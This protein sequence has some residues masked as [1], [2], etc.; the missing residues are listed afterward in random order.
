MGGERQGEGNTHDTLGDTLGDTRNGGD[1]ALVALET[2]LGYRFRD[3]RLLSVALTHKSVV[4]QQSYERMEFLGDRLLGYL[5]AETLY[6]RFP[7]DNEGELSK[8]LA[9]AVSQKHISTIA[10]GWQAGSAAVL[11]C[12]VRKEGFVERPGLLADLCESIL[13]AVYLD[14]GLE[15]LRRIVEQH[16]GEAF[17]DERAKEGDERSLL[18]EWCQARALPLPDY[19]CRAE[20][21]DHEKSFCASVSV[22]TLSNNTYRAEAVGS[23]KKLAM[24]QAAAKLFTRI[25]N[26]EQEQNQDKSP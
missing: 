6:R 18:Q 4:K 10:R 1:V 13:A 17:L 20:G 11:S 25:Q 9:A 5:V 24:Q 12:E 2:R 26:Q 16:W 23:S 21:P 15:A 7:Q 22:A 3:R 8:R 19:V 14:G